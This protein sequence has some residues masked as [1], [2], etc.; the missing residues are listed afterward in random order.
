M[1]FFL[2]IAALLGLACGLQA[3]PQTDSL[4]A[5]VQH[6]IHR[7]HLDSLVENRKAAFEALKPALQELLQSPKSFEREWNIEGISE[8]RAQ[9]N[10]VKVFSWQLFVHKDS[11]LYGGI[12][13]TAEGKLYP[14][15]DK[16]A[17][18]KPVHLSKLKPETWHGALYYNILTFEH[19]GK[20]M[21]LLLGLH[22]HN[23]QHR[24]KLIEVLHFGGPG[25]A[26]RFGEGVLEQKNPQ[27]KIVKINRLVIEYSAAVSATLNW[28][29]AD[30]MIIYDHLVEDYPLP[31]AGPANVP[32]GSY[33]GL[34]L[35]KEVW[36]HVD[37]PHEYTY[38]RSTSW[39][40]PTAPLDHAIFNEKTKQKDIFGR[41]RQTSKKSTD[42]QPDFQMK[43]PR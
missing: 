5:K 24:R 38:D 20:P 2:S 4:K 21:Y 36:T 28:S 31:G 30:K 32:D 6:L 8:L 10:K 18:A 9:D 37:M 39:N 25:G 1:R 14:L 11:Y 12:I 22:S 40:N 3:A 33:I 19:K 35:D 13:Q 16:T 15:T 27:G 23:F 42:K 17:E 29:P 34:K 43:A 7:V 26:P 41:R